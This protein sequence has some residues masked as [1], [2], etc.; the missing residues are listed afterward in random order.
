MN[1]RAVS[2]I[3]NWVLAVQIRRA[4]LPLRSTAEAI[5]RKTFGLVLSALRIPYALYQF[6]MTPQS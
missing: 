3:P 1:A 5:K 4:E 2:P 6:F